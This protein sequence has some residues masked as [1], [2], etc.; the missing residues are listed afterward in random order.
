MD[1]NASMGLLSTEGTSAFVE[2][3]YFRNTKLPMMINM[4]GTNYQIWPTGSQNG[5][6]IKAFNNIIEGG[7]P[8]IYQ[9]QDPVQFDAYQVTSRNE[10]IPSTVKS[11][12]GGNTYNNFDTASTM[13]AYIPDA[14]SNVKTVVT[15]NAGRVN[16]GDF[17]WTFTAA[18][19][20][21]SAINTALKQK[22]TDYVSP[23]VAR[24]TAT[25]TATATPTP[26]AE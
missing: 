16:G 10:T 5:G 13:Y 7:N 22:I 18:D 12:K 14:P 21:L 3:N 19:D 23:L 25:P 15:A 24:P 6:M 4:Q 17:K 8:V 9:T 11:V 2:A 1:G 20:T 26:T